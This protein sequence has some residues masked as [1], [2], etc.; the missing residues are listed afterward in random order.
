LK[1][2]YP[3]KKTS[4]ILKELT[5]STRDIQ[6]QAL[7]NKFGFYSPNALVA[8]T[9]LITSNKLFFHIPHD[10]QKRH[11]DYNPQFDVAETGGNCVGESLMIIHELSIGRLK[12]L[13]PEFATINF[14]L[15]QT[16]QLPFGKV[17]LGEG[18][19]NVSA[20]SIY[21]SVHWNDVEKVII[22]NPLFK[23]GDL[24]GLF[25]SMNEYTS[26]RRN[27]TPGHI[28]VV[29][30][31]DVQQSPYKYIVFEKEL[32]VFG[33]PDDESLEY[34]VTEHIM[35]LYQGMNYSKIQLTKHGE[36]TAAT[37]HFINSFQPI[38]GHG[39]TKSLEQPRN[40][41]F[42]NTS[43]PSEKYSLKPTEFKISRT[44]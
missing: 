32:G 16:R 43:T 23:D 33:L 42:F 39:A 18:E 22:S 8:C 15:D 12:R 2:S 5:K 17:L 6:R 24:C 14:Q 38:T 36:A 1:N 25:F 41:S 31:L 44:I 21:H 19:T 3:I 7:L 35:A 27:F 26:S 40:N 9:H 13:C 34:I 4:P 28:A 29:A 30:K 37:Y 11:I 10:E 20:Q